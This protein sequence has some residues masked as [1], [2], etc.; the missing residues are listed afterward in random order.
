MQLDTQRLG[1]Q[2]HSGLAPVYLLSGDEPL[3]VEES[4]DAIR[5]AARQQGYEERISLMA[6]PG[7]DWSRLSESSQTLSLFASRRL[8]EIRIP[9]GRPGDAGGKVLLEFASQPSEDTVLVVV[10]GRLEKGQRNSKWYKAL[11]QAGVSVIAWPVDAQKLP[12]WIQARLRQR[13]LQAEPE[14]VMLLAHYMEGNL[15]AAAQEI[16]KLALLYPDARVTAERVEAGIADNARFDVYGLVDTCLQ[17]Q[18]AMAMRMLRGLKAEGVPPVLVIWSLAREVRGLLK[19]ARDTAAGRP[20][21]Q[22]VKAHRVWARRAPLVSRALAR[23][24]YARLLELLRGLARLDRVLKGRA[25]GEIWSELEMFSVR[26]CGL[27][28]GG[29][30]LAPR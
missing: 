13:G 7:F 8:I 5:Q 4:L 19:M 24:P 6:E 12:G 17:G 15:L 26:L 28:P 11:D 10:C 20:V 1:A 16:D 30:P 2:L 18:A 22:V 14:A 3:L 21:G 23:L 27:E 9:S 29:K 25:A